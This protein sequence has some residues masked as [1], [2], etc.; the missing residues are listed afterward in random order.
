[1]KALINARIF[2]FDNYI[3]NGYIVFSDKI[4][5]IGKMADFSEGMYD[6]T[7]CEG[8]LIMPSLVCGHTHIY[9]AF[10][11][12]LILPLNPNN[13]QEILDQLWWK[14]DSKIDNAITYSSGI[15][16]GIDHLKNG[17][18]TLI[19]HHA[20]GSEISGS[21]DAL[22]EALVDRIGMRGIFAF[23]TSDRFDVSLAIEENMRFIEENKTHFASGLFGMHASMSLSDETLKEIK[24]AFKDNP[25]HIHVAESVM[26]EDDSIKKHGR[27][28]MERLDKFG[29]LSKDSI[30]VHCI[31][32]NELEMD[33][34]KKT[35]GVVCLNVSSNMNNGVG[36]PDYKK[37]KS[38]GIPVIIGNDGLN[39]SMAN[40][41]M[42]LLYASHLLN[43]SLMG[44]SLMDLK[45]VI[46]ETYLYASRQLD[47]KLGRLLPGYEA[48]MLVVP[49][50]PPTPMNRTNALGHLFYGL[51]SAFKPRHVYVAGKILVHDYAVD[52][53]LQE[54]YE[55]SMSK[56]KRLWHDLTT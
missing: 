3:E 37:L 4:V 28:I 42:N 34:I 51:F 33:L 23:E 32:I 21:L 56:A 44:F 1:M 55:R 15:V 7:N 35:G 13:F 24:L 5:E 20:S 50:T 36:L 29:L 54:E 11:R 19:D 46:D 43:K 48:D 9:S 18:T 45:N 53:S 31:H 26:D 27:R 38:R 14:I 10:A 47:I 49:Y 39:H 52:Q 17:V 16:S 12:G 2:D 6:T 40:E 41:Y 25:F 30:Y 22:K 8:Q